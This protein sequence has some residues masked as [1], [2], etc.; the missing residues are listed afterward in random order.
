LA[1]LLC[2]SFMR[3]ASSITMYFQST[4]THGLQ[5]Q[6][7]AHILPLHSLLHA[8]EINLSILGGAT[9]TRTLHTALTLCLG[10]YI[11]KQLQTK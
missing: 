9:S 7:S 4:C 10:I 11:D 1:S 6:P 2:R 3:C 5:P 8:S